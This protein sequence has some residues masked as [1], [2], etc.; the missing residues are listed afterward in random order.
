MSYSGDLTTYD[1]EA[2]E[3]WKCEYVGQ[4]NHIV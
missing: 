4:L 3:D 2:D 1:K